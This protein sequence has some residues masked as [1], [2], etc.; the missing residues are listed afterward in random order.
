MRPQITHENTLSKA[1]I[2]RK[3][4]G[5]ECFPN[6]QLRVQFVKH[7]RTKYFVNTEAETLIL[8]TIVNIP[9]QLQHP[10][11]SKSGVLV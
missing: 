1:I 4:R 2:K 3:P 8:L 10:L 5:T 9:S 6:S 7:G 11:Q